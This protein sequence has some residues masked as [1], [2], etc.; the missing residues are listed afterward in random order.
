M[1]KKD[2]GAHFQTPLSKKAMLSHLARPSALQPVPH[3]YFR[4]ILVNVWLSHLAINTLA[5]G[6]N[7]FC[8]S[9]ECAA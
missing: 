3:S 1:A 7:P 5:E 2:R 4:A 8:W 9:I 6:N